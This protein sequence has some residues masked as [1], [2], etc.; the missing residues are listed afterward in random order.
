VARRHLRYAFGSF[1]EQHQEF[2]MFVRRLAFSVATAAVLAAPGRAPADTIY[3]SFVFGAHPEDAAPLGQLLTFDFHAA[4]PFETGSKGYTLESIT[5]SLW[6][7]VDANTQNGDWKVR[8]REQAPNNLPGTVLEEWT[9]QNNAAPGQTTVHEFVSVAT[10]ALLPGKRYWVHVSTEP[11]SGFAAWN[12]SLALTTDMLFAN[13]GDAL[14]PNWEFPTAPYLV[15]LMTVV[16]EPGQVLLL[17]SGAAALAA[18]GLRR[19]RA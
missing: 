12:G 9:L 17:V 16:P 10:P 18:A 2:T 14:N 3:D 1:L 4:Y 5:R 11:S 15:A 13:S 19:R 7:D 6:T 8:L